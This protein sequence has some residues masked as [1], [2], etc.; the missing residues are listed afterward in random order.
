MGD[1]L[2]TLYYISFSY[3]SVC[4]IVFV[5]IK[6]ISVFAC[7]CF[8]TH[9]LLTQYSLIDV[10]VCAAGPSDSA[11]RSGHSG[12]TAAVVV[13]VLFVLLLCVCGGLVALYVRHRRLQHSFTA[14]ANSHY[15]SR[16][17]SAIFSSGYELGKSSTC[18][19]ST[20]KTFPI[21]FYPSLLT[22]SFFFFVTYTKHSVPSR[23][24]CVC[25]FSKRRR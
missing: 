15:N 7:L 16:L 19:Y 20:Y 13:P 6:A 23:H 18:S 12:D 8:V 1:S 22:L 10:C 2:F 5:S 25:S 14:F 17:G 9:V 21:P 11:A 4:L 3:F 24:C